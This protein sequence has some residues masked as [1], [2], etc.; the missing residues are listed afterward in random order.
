M[1][2]DIEY[3]SFTTAAETEE[4]G[5]VSA[6]VSVFSNLDRANEKIRPGFFTASLERRLPRV[7]W[8]HD[9]SRPLGKTL[10]ARELAPGDPLL[11]PPIAHLGGLWVKGKLNLQTTAGRDAYEHLRAGDLDEFSIGYKVLA[12]AVDKK[13][14]IRELIR[15]D[16][17]EWSPVL[18]GCNPQ[19][20][21]LDLKALPAESLSPTDD[22]YARAGR[23]RRLIIDQSLRRHAPKGC[24]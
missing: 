14:G 7:C 21:L 19:T 10:E 24:D 23:M 18:V 13:T 3:K 1:A 15:G 16:C 2:S 17:Y 5:V 22:D 4:S 9:W 12:D 8:S 6:I 11:P 20:A